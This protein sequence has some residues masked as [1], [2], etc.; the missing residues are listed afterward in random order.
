MDKPR[1]WTIC[2][3]CYMHPDG[4]PIAKI[5]TLKFES[6]PNLEIGEKL[7]VIEKTA[8]TSLLVEAREMQ[9]ALQEIIIS[10][11]ECI[12]RDTTPNLS[13]LFRA[14]Q[15]I[16]NFDKYIKEQNE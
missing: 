10:N 13:P 12:N 3:S 8:F 7:K 11:S 6:G 4:Y 14:K 1:E 2:G 16:S 5:K 9:G 15:S